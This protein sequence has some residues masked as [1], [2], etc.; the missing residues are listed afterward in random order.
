MTENTYITNVL[1]GIPNFGRRVVCDIAD[2]IE[3]IRCIDAIDLIFYTNDD[4]FHKIY[5]WIPERIQISVLRLLND[6]YREQFDTSCLQLPIEYFKLYYRYVLDEPFPLIIRNNEA[7]IT[8]SISLQKLFNI[9]FLEYNYPNNLCIIIDMITINDYFMQSYGR[10]VNRTLNITNSPILSYVLPTELWLAIFTH[11]DNKTRNTMLLINKMFYHVLSKENYNL[12]CKSLEKYKW[13]SKENKYMMGIKNGLI[14]YE[15]KQLKQKTEEPIYYASRNIIKR[16]GNNFKIDHCYNDLIEF[17]LVL[18][19]HDE[20]NIIES[21]K[22]EYIESLI[23]LTYYAYHKDHKV[24]PF[25]DDF[26]NKMHSPK[27]NRYVFVPEKKGDNIKV[28]KFNII[29]KEPLTHCYLTSYVIYKT[30]VCS[31]IN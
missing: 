20:T 21:L 3:D 7:N 22:L 31:H 2:H 5:E 6:T 25:E 30:H 24:I 4:I 16:I 27:E 14:G 18:A 17:V 13:N 26:Y 1:N 9:P 19:D 23:P 12:H 29:L 11:A 28:Y 10:L 15:L 8:F